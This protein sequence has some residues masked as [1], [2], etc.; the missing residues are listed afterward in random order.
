MPIFI[1]HDIK[2]DLNSVTIKATQLHHIGTG[3]LVWRDWQYPAVK[4]LLSPIIAGD[5]DNDGYV[6]VL[7]IITLV[8]LILQGDVEYFNAGDFNQ[9]GVIDILD[10]V[11]MVNHIVGD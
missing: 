4:D 11:G 7:D 9:D 1:I 10:V 3:T 8:N 6:T 2:K 5:I